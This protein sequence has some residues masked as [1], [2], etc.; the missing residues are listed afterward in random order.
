M[1]ATTLAQNL[2]QATLIYLSFIKRCHD[3]Q[4]NDIQ[5]DN[6]QDSDIQDKK[7]ETLSIMAYNTAL[8][9]V[10]NK[11]IMLNIIMLSVM[12]PFNAV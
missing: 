12:A 6:I 3:T 9:I 8:L 10:T 1:T 2:L 5:H 11:P 7:I 4:H